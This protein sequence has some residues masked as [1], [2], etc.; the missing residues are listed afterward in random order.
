MGRNIHLDVI[1]SPLT[2]KIRYGIVL[3]KE[4]GSINLDTT[5][6]MHFSTAL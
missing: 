3:D 2:D 4:Q 5:M 6:M 1:Y